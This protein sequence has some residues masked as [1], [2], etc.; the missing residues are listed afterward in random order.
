MSYIILSHIQCIFTDGYA[1][2]AAVLLVH[3]QGK[4]DMCPAFA[5]NIC[6][7]TYSQECMPPS[8][9][10]QDESHVRETVA[11]PGLLPHEIFKTS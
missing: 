8:K 1:N 11:S 6:L 9:A 5:A 3:T 2:Q 7:S 10:L 4:C